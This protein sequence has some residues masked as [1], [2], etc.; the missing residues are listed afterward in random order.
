MKPYEYLRQ[1]INHKP[2]SLLLL[3]PVAFPGVKVSALFSVDYRATE[4]S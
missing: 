2:E 4:T 3:S 1:K